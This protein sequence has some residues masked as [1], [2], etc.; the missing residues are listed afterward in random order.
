MDTL[1]WLTLDA[2]QAGALLA[3][4]ATFGA[5]ALHRRD[6]MMGWLAA[7]CLLVAFRHGVGVLDLARVLP[8]EDGDRI[9]S[10]LGTLGFMA[11]VRSLALL[12][13]GFYPR[14]FLRV[15]AAGATPNLIRCAMLPLEGLTA[16]I[17]HILTLGT[18]L[19]A[20]GVTVWVLFRAHRSRD[21]LGVRLLA[22]L[23]GTMIPVVV[24]I[25]ARLIYG[26]SIRVSGVSIMLM[27]IT[28]GVSWVWVQTLDLQ[29]RRDGLEAEVKAW[30]GLLPGVTWHSGEG[31]GLLD[32]LLGGAWRSRAGERVLGRDGRLYIPRSAL[33]PDGAQVGWL[34]PL[35]R[36][37]G[38]GGPFLQGWTVGLGLDDPG[39]TDR[40]RVW[41]T[42][43]GAQVEAWGTV[44]PREGPFPSLLIWGREPSILA[45][46]REYDLARR[47][48][49]WIQVGGH[50]GD[51]PH[52]RVERP[53]EAEAL[54][55]ALRGLL[56]LQQ[57]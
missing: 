47:R 42:S 39:E 52:A 12:F 5:D 19:W 55:A 17:F 56:A 54:R 24:E 50:A 43:W 37:T 11:L 28:V 21:P 1:P 44:P 7:C 51:G 16:K 30:R 53:L 38:Q 14:R 35:H 6:R 18:Y 41:L 2:L 32:G 34:E 46:W 48:C 49:R 27:A 4:A 20:C 8:V 22:G 31:S 36:E 57:A 3:L 33:L 13:P 25:L 15:F 40:V 45:V 26:V 10:L 9:Q 23:I 29:A